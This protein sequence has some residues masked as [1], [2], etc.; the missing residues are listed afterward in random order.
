MPAAQFPVI[1]A[2]PFAETRD[3]L[4][5]STY[6]KEV[7]EG[8]LWRRLRG[9][10]LGL[11]V[12]DDG[13]GKRSRLAIRSCR[14]L[15]LRRAHRRED[16][17]GA[18]GRRDGGAMLST[19]LSYTLGAVRWEPVNPISEHRPCPSPGGRFT[20]G[21]VLSFEAE[22][23]VASYR[24]QPRDH[25]LVAV[26]SRPGLQVEPETVAI[27]LSGDLSRCAS[28]YGDL[29]YCLST[30]EA[31]AVLAQ[32]ALVLGTFGLRVGRTEFS[33]P[34]S[35]DDR[36]PGLT[37]HVPAPAIAEWLRTATPA[38]LAFAEEIYPA[39]GSADHPVLDALLSRAGSAQACS[40]VFAGGI[41][42]AWP[43]NAA[44][45][46]FEATAARSSGLDMAAGSAANQAPDQTSVSTLLEAATALHASF[47]GLERHGIGLT[48]SLSET[49]AVEPP[50]HWRLAPGST[51][52]VEVIPRGA[53]RAWGHVH[54]PGAVIATISADYRAYL[55]R[56]GALALHNMYLAT[57]IAAQTVCLASA[58]AGLVCRPMR[59][60]D[61]TAADALL[62]IDH[63]SVLQLVIY[64]DR[65][66]A[67][68]FPVAAVP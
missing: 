7:L 18:Q 33:A 19:I 62:P 37:L 6:R 47:A 65:T 26:D 5:G 17:P 10:L 60:F 58:N 42:A 64:A 14:G 11:P 13:T 22:G 52:S 46:L 40:D 16:E 54:P 12:A 3:Y 57:G 23:G 20:V 15:A 61:H 9:Q 56:F 48:A 34:L 35:G 38:K 68:A 66:G 29:A 1:L 53:D 51:L 55:A 59:S 43:A 4:V 32:M 50:A 30:I 39:F 28:P 67:P 25:I 36:V 44:C 8:A 45:T 31:G 27:T 21:A 41:A 24:Y 49:V 2:G 63:W